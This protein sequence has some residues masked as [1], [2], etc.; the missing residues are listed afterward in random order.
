MTGRDYLD[1]VV[2][3]KGRVMGVPRSLSSLTTNPTNGWEVFPRKL[4]LVMDV[5]RKPEERVVETGR[6]T[7]DGIAETRIITSST[8]LVKSLDVV[9]TEDI[10]L[11]LPAGRPDVLRSRDVRWV[12]QAWCQVGGELRTIFLAAHR[13]GNSEPDT[14]VTFLLEPGLAL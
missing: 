6:Q 12:V 4:R 1:G 11:V 9:L 5:V 3:E 10:R 7:S 14:Y 2:V 13:P 8:V